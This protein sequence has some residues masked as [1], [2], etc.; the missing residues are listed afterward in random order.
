MKTNAPYEKLLNTITRNDL[1]V[2]SLQIVIASFSANTLSVLLEK[3]NNYTTH[4]VKDKHEYD[5]YP[6]VKQT[7]FRTSR[8]NLEIYR[9]IFHKICLISHSGTKSER[10]KIHSQENFS[11]CLLRQPHSGRTVYFAIEVT[12]SS[13]PV[14]GLSRQWLNSP[15]C[16]D[17]PEGKTLTGT[18]PPPRL[19]YYSKFLETSQH[20]WIGDEWMSSHCQIN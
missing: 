1:K 15:Y 20:F 11:R 7:E 9:H 3:V 19:I 17:R 13:C 5:I 4:G 8:H 18:C 6:F 10:N 14:E 12:A 2:I 16:Q